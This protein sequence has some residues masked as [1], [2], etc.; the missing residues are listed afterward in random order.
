VGIRVEAIEEGAIDELG[1][2]GAG[3]GGR[4]LVRV[5]DAA[6]VDDEDGGGGPG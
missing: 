5:A 3:Q 1:R 6:L 4:R 2:G